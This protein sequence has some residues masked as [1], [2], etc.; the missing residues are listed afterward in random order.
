MT[1]SIKIDL[2]RITPQLDSLQS[3]L[4]VRHAEATR[5]GA[6]AGGRRLPPMAA[7][8]LNNNNNSNNNVGAAASS[9]TTTIDTIST[10]HGLS[11]SD[12]V[13]SGLKGHLLGVASSLRGVVAARGEAVAKSSE[14]RQIFGGAGALRDL[15]RPIDGDAIIAIGPAPTTTM[16]IQ[17]QNHQH[18]AGGGGSGG[19]GSRA[20]DKNSF[21]AV[22]QAQLSRDPELQYLSAR[23][24][25]VA[26]LEST[27]NEL[28]TLFGRL[29]LVVAEQGA[30]VERIDADLEMAEGDIERGTAQLQKAWNTVS[31]NRTLALRVL[32]V[33]VSFA[34]FYSVVLI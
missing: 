17:Q 30:T 34:I 8:V 4:K 11:H 31:S 22:T 7:Q 12:A 28:G 24:Q 18:F 14:R 5:V 32:G 25:D 26:G 29:A 1:L 3:V 9:S 21:A 13:L 20:S 33:V 27:I 6:S 2:Q 16:N 10:V 19:G 15:G 23:A